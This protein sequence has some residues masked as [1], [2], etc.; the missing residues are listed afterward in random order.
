MPIRAIVYFRQVLHSQR[1][2]RYT[3]SGVCVSHRPMPLRGSH[4]IVD[5][6]Q[7]SHGISTCKGLSM[8]VPNM[9]HSSRFVQ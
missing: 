8:A 9:M 6:T 3:L 5:I 7:E 2:W 1:N 4:L